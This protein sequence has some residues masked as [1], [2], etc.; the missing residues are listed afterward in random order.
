MARTQSQLA[1]LKS[2]WD[3]CKAQ[4]DQKNAL[5]CDLFAYVDDLSSKLSN[6][7]AELQDKRDAI[8]VVRD[9]VEQ[10][11]TEIQALKHEKARHAF[12]LVVIDGDSMPFLDE[13][14]QKGLEG[15]KKAAC[16]LKQAIETELKTSIP[17]IS[18]HMDVIIRVFANIEGLS[19]IY[20]ESKIAPESTTIDFIRGFNMGHALCDFVDAGNG[21]EC[22]DEKVKAVF[23]THLA[24][25]HCQRVFF[26]GSTD[27]GYARLLGPYIEDQRNRALITLLEGPRFAPELASIQ[28]KFQTVSF[29]HVFRSRKLP[30]LKG[31][32][33]LHITPPTTPSVNYAS[34]LNKSQN[35]AMKGSS[36]TTQQD[37]G[38]GPPSPPK[39]VLRN[40]LGQRIDPP[41]GFAPQDL[42][43]IKA[44]KLCNS[45]HLL[46]KCQYLDDF[47]N[48]NHE[49]G[50][51]LSPIETD[52]LRIIARQ[53]PCLRG[54]YCDDQSCFFGHRCTRS[55]CVPSTCR[56][57]SE[58]H[59]VD[60]RTVTVI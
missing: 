3:L 45:F 46:G 11:K 52:K 49:H 56:F 12:A 36:P 10:S 20:R 58:M 6:A 18:H 43:R 39:P 19:M 31:R 15:G 47:G 22:A 23:K 9:Q 27:S 40:R 35:V 37:S 8:R 54:P 1:G 28:A 4:D 32:Q 14:V 42:A 34:V 29:K 55:D 16:L 59:N 17:D 50:K 38:F 57:P 51:A 7:D 2:K 25:V 30:D 48:C 21:K 44:R 60:T 13:L 24:H 41:H 33:S 26:G 5:I 53:S